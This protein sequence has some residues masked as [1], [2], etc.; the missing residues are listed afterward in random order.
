[1]KKIITHNKNNKKMKYIKKFESYTKDRTREEMIS[2]LC[3]CGWEE[4]ELENKEDSELAE[5]CKHNPDEMSE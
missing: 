2:H 4:C 5:M 1:M 3:N